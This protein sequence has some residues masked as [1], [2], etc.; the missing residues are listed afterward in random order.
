MTKFGYKLSSEEHPARDLVRQARQAEE[1]GFDFAMLSDH[2]HPWVDAQGES[3]FAWSVLGA[4]ANAT[5]QIAIGTAVTCPSLRVHPGV[6]AQAAATMAT[7]A[8]GRFWLGLGTGE[9][10]NEHIFGDAW[11]SASVR[12][13]MLE[14]AIEV[15]RGLWRGDAYDHEGRHYRVQQ[16]R[17]YSLPRRPPP[18]YIA[19]AG[20]EAAEMAGRLGD[21]LISVAPDQGLVET[22][23]ETGD[24][25]RPT[26]AEITVC[27][28]ADEPQARKIALEI[29]PNA[30]IAGELSAE[31]PLPRHFEQASKLVTSEGIA[32]KIVCG[33]E[34]DA[35]IR[36]AQKYIDAG[37]D[38]V[39][40][41]QVGPDQDGFFDFYR[42]EVLPALRDRSG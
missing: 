1:V 19:A 27:W 11:P 36:I 13:E 29:W 8:P 40:F 21:G 35:H 30:G 31:L 25:S 4:V 15:I 20:E 37:F 2:Y 18:I 32:E 24:P 28:A 17:L 10:L 34:P 3:P 6:I 9:N 42:S 41:H 5:D 7:L 23:R 14:E 39:W 16:A 26:L 38:H 22:F 12:R 33:P